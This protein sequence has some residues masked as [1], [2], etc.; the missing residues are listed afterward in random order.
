MGRTPRFA[1]LPRRSSA[2]LLNLLVNALR[3]TPSDGTVAVVVEPLER[4]VRLS[5]EDTGEGLPADA[6]SRLFERLW[7]GDPARS[8]TTG[9]A[10]L[11]LAI[12]RGLVEAQGGRTWAENVAARASR[13]LCHG[14]A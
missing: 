12:A 11:G 1:A 8:R 7:R 14:P 4:E 3:Q 10:G 13:S 5:V 9:G 2:L 6:S